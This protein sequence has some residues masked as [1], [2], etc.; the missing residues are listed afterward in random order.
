[1]KQLI[2]KTKYKMLKE[3]DFVLTHWGKNDRKN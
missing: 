3:S 2:N 1:M